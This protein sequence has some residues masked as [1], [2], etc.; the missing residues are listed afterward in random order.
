MIMK[1]SLPHI[2]LGLRK[3]PINFSDW[4]KDK[5]GSLYFRISIFAF[6]ILVGLG[7]ML[8]I[9]FRKPLTLRIIH[10]VDMDIIQQVNF[11]KVDFSLFR[12]FPY[13][14]VRFSD[15]TTLGS[16]DLGSS[17]LLSVK[18]I[19]IAVD[20]WSVLDKT[21]S[22]FIRSISF[23]EP[24]LTLLISRS[25]KK[26]YEVPLTRAW[27]NPKD[28]IPR[29][30]LYFNLDL[31]SIVI[32][33]GFLL[34][35]DENANIDI[36]ADGIRHAGSG[37]ISTNFY[38]LRTKTSADMVDIA[39]GASTILNKAKM[40]LD[41]DFIVDNMDQIY[42]IKDNSLKINGLSL[43]V[44]GKVK[45]NTDNYYCDFNV[46]APNNQFNEL[47]QLF[48]SFK[49]S[50]FRNFQNTKGD[51]N[52][53][54]SI[55]GPFQVLPRIYPAFQGFLH[56][57]NASIQ[58]YFKEGG[59]SD[60]QS[61]I[62]ICNDS[63]DLKNL[64]IHIPKLEACVEGKDFGLG[65]Y[66]KNPIYDP[67][68]HGFVKGELNLNS[69]NKY[70]PLFP[71]QSLSGNLHSDIFIKG[72]MSDIDRKNYKEVIMNGSFKWSN[73]NWRN[74]KF[75]V[76]INSMKAILTPEYLRFPFFKGNFNGNEISVSGNISN[77]LALFSP[78]NTLKGN[79]L[80]TA[81]ETNL[82]KWII[83]EKKT[84]K[85]DI[86]KIEDQPSLSH[87]W[88]HQRES[89]LIPYDVH[90]SFKARNIIYKGSQFDAFSFA[91][92]YQP[93][94][95]K[96]KSTE[97]NYQTINIKA[98]GQLLN[99]DSYFARN[100]MIKGQLDVRASKFP[101]T[102]PSP[103]LVSQSRN[104][105]EVMAHRP[106]SENLYVF[107][108]KVKQMQPA[109]LPERMEIRG[110]IMIDSISSDQQVFDRISFLLDLKKDHVRM[111]K[112]VA[113]QKTMP[114]Y[115]KGFLNRQN[116]FAVSFDFSK[117]RQ[118]LFTIPKHS[119]IQFF[120]LNSSD[121][122]NRPDGLKI[123][124]NISK[125]PNYSFS[126]LKYLFYL[127]A[128]NYPE[129][130]LIKPFNGFAVNTKKRNSTGMKWW[131]TYEQNKFTFWPFFL[132]FN[133]IPFYFTGFQQGERDCHFMIAG[134]L[135]LS[136]FKLEDKTEPIKTFNYPEKI[137]VVLYVDECSTNN[138]TM[139]LEVKSPFADDIK[140]NLE[141]YLK[142]ELNKELRRIYGV[143]KLKNTPKVIN[144]KHFDYLPIRYLQENL[145][146]WDRHQELSD[147][148]QLVFNT[149]KPAKN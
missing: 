108:R 96:I 17:E 114:I 104:K 49:N 109:L 103:D 29:K 87:E 57:K 24:K 53:G 148:L 111:T 20:I 99:V 59:I 143:D 55:K 48:P 147:S 30:K 68:V 47:L 94:H 42:I 136:Y 125:A 122:I 51:F 60:I 137:E 72:K 115:W 75:F 92:N 118:E 107:T 133:D 12:S 8:P 26:N 112:G 69:L 124:G 141:Q 11:S 62:S 40:S 71:N 89:S 116:N 13:L 18:H 131:I 134:L 38:R 88:Q 36:K 86:I 120:K 95:L 25:G 54:L 33:N 119:P 14:S 22:I 110:K 106:S 2:L 1:F 135:P 61:Y 138:Y 23:N 64:E 80:V 128:K 126:K 4:I 3:G 16:P 28:S 78:L 63:E 32:N 31:Q 123:S 50:T 9:I 105:S 129:N 27:I 6:V 85:I 102:L 144:K 81:L 130:A 58:D 7:I 15:F 93:N 35:R 65:L 44:K 149:L 21:R 10:S 117:Y 73:I 77:I 39:F 56:I 97:F 41:V 146:I 83:P 84:K 145:L 139:H 91:G 45:K 37:D 46:F 66:V 19:D 121:M 98:T 67:F 142:Y 100:G 140:N 82:D 79:V 127:Q 74:K 132:Q 43:L 34:I 113:Y 52:L 101:F 5:W 90:F 76:K 70:L